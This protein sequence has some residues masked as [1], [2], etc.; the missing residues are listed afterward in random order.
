[1]ILMARL[2]EVAVEMKF[3]YGES[4]WE[5]YMQNTLTLQCSNQYPIESE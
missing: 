3:R 4:W 2:E 1:M 5:K